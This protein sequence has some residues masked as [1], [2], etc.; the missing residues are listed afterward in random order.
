MAMV[1]RQTAEQQH[2]HQRQQ[3]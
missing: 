1:L 3:R 2:Q